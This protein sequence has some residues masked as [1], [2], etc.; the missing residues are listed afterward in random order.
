MAQLNVEPKKNNS[1]WPWLLVALVALALLFFFTKGC[2]NKGNIT[3]GSDTTASDT[4]AN[5]TGIDSMTDDWSSIDRSA[6][7]AAYDE[8]TDKDIEVRGNDQ[9]AI[10]SVEETL[11]FDTDKNTIKHGA[12]QKLK[13]VAASAEKRFANGPIRIYGYTDS[14]GTAAHNKQLAEERANAVSSWLVANGNISQ[15]RI[16]INPVGEAQ[17]AATNTTTEG[18]KQNRRVEIVVRKNSGS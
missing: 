4:T 10:Y 17:P 1:W 18:R 2:N 11:L 15:D 7:A 12:E 3:N 13:Q 16:S 9:Y 6:P 14:T 5:A 8:V